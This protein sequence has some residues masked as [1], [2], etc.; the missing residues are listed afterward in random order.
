MAASVRTLL[1]SAC[2]MLSGTAAGASVGRLGG[3]LGRVENPADVEVRAFLSAFFDLSRNEDIQR[4]SPFLIN[5]SC[6]FRICYM[7]IP[8]NVLLFIC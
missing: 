7:M 3:G 2:T 6:F 1:S 4:L 5:A 8:N